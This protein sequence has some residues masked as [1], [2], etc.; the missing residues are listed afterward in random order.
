MT[1]GGSLGDTFKN[2]KKEEIGF[3]DNDVVT[4]DNPTVEVYGGDW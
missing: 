2:P 1:S 4:K 3:N